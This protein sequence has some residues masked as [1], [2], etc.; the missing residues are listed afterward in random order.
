MYS[1]TRTK[2]LEESKNSNQYQINM[3][4]IKKNS[5]KFQSNL[6]ED[7]DFMVTQSNKITSYR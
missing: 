3:V 2:T 1:K 7:D 6:E 4:Q 5:K